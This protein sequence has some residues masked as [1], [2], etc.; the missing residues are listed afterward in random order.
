LQPNAEVNVGY[1]QYLFK[2]H[3]YIQ[4]LRATS[5]FIRDGQDLNLS[6]FALVDL[7]LPPPDMQRLIA[8]FLDWHSGQTAK[9]IRAKKKI[10]ALLN[11]QKQAIIYRAATRGLEQSW[12]R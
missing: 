9:L 4:A 6:N 11:E 3:Y 12:L 7:P 5:N 8:R 1:F 2:S 10:I